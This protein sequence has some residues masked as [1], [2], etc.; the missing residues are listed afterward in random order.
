MEEIINLMA[1]E[2][3]SFNICKS[4]NEFTC[5]LYIMYNVHLM[6]SS[7]WFP[8]IK[9]KKCWKF[10]EYYFLFTHFFR[11]YLYFALFYLKERKKES[12][13]AMLK[14]K[15]IYFSQ[16]TCRSNKTFSTSLYSTVYEN[17]KISHTKS[18]KVLFRFI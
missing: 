5:F 3:W 13:T 8:D 1:L 2:R 4:S 9:K 16:V 15:E 10:L 14:E 12:H 11:L 18:C 7:R 17:Q 6:P